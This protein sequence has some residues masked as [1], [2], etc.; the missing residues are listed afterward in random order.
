MTTLRTFAVTIMAIGTT[1]SLS[2]AQAAE[3]SE[4]RLRSGKSGVQATQIAGPEVVVT[5]QTRVVP[6]HVYQSQQNAAE[7]T[8]VP[9]GYKRV[10]G[11]ERF[12]PKRAHQTLY[13]ME[14]SNQIL[15][16]TV[17]RTSPSDQVR[18][19]NQRRDR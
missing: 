3:P 9:A 5:S 1:V 15:S 19:Q 14:Q 18:G 12:N 16:S 2:Q 8:N 7:I 6:K 10:W 11:E 4:L 17:P 13:G